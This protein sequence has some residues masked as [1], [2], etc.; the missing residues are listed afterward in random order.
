MADKIS[1]IQGNLRAIRAAMKLGQ[2]DFGAL[3]N[4]P[5]STYVHYENGNSEPSIQA[6][7]R[8]SEITGKSIETL[9]NTDISAIPSCE[10]QESILPAVSKLAIS[11]NA[12]NQDY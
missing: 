9:I 11:P 2:V 10:L 1:Y 7:V 6:M 5:R 8:L 12:K 4:I 3:L